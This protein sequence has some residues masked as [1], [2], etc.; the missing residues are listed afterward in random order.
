MK[1]QSCVRPGGYFVF[2][3]HKPR[4]RAENFRETEK[5][6]HLGEFADGSVCDNRINFPGA[7]VEEEQADPIYEIVNPFPFRGCTFIIKSAADRNAADISRICLPQRPEM[8]MCKTLRDWHGKALPPDKIRDFFRA[9]PPPVLLALA[10]NSTD[11]L[12]LTCIADDCC[13]FIRDKT[14]KP[15]G[16]PYD[17]DAQGRPVA[18]IKDHHLCEVLANNICLPDAYKEVMVLRPGVQGASEIMGEWEK[19][20]SHVF[21]Y[22]RRNSYIP[23]GHYAANMAHDA[24]RYRCTDLTAADAEGMRHLYYQRT[25]ARMAEE[26]G[27]PLPAKKRTL[28]TAELEDLRKQICGMLSS[29]KEPAFGSTL[30]GWNFGFDFAPSRYRLH[31][32]HQQIHQQYALIPSRIPSSATEAIPAFAYGDLIADFIRQYKE[33][34]GQDFFT[35]Y[36]RAIRSNRRTDGNEKGP[37]KLIV[38]EDEHV[39]LFVPKAQTSQWELQLMTLQPVGNI[40]E[41]DTDTRASLDRALRMAAQ[42]LETLGARMITHTEA[43]KR[44]TAGDTEQRLLY[45]FL[46]RLPYSPG[47]FTEAQLRWING[48][49]PEDFAAACRNCLPGKSPE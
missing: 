37:Q 12:D 23:W 11:P 19:E 46:P 6:T 27:I 5:I 44:F 42:I 4:F 1:V 36:L 21:E 32:S 15:L 33:D 29:G 9:L 35:T 43:S 41:A 47:S 28:T 14:G 26:L 49:Y 13:D 40:L 16:L 48:H 17:R 45:C 25:Y 39:M 2:G 3:I 24:V 22:F 7:A 31:A 34:W 10:A 18:R 38:F 30:W 20:K 8:S